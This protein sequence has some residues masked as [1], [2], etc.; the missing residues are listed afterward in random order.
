MKAVYLLPFMPAAALVAA[1]MSVVPAGESRWK[2]VPSI[3]S[4]LSA[5]TLL[6]LAYRGWERHVGPGPFRW[7]W[8]TLTAVNL[9]FLVLLAVAGP[10]SLLLLAGREGA[11]GRK[12]RVL[13]ALGH[14][15]LAGAMTAALSGHLILLSA[16]CALATWCAAAT[17]LLVERAGRERSRSWAALFPFLAS[18]LC[19]A[20]SVLLMALKGL[21]R[22]LLLSS[23]PAAEVDCLPAFV[24]MLAAAL[25]R[26][27]VFPLNA[28]AAF[29][30]G[31]GRA[32]RL[33]Y[34]QVVNPVLGGYL[35]FLAVRVVFSP[36]R[37]WQW[38]MLGVGS[39]VLA[40]SALS[41]LRSANRGGVRGWVAACLGG[42]FAL[43]L[44]GGGQGGAA[45]A[46][47][48]LLSGIPA[49]L[50]LE[51]SEGGGWRRWAGVAGG[52]ALLGIPPLAGFGSLW[53]AGSSL[54]EGHAGGSGAVF[55][56]GWPVVVLAF[57][58]GG[59]VTLLAPGGEADGAPAWVAAAVSLPLLAVLVL[60]GVYPGRVVDLFMREYGL[61]ME[62]PFS[63]WGSLAWASILVLAGLGLLWGTRV[64]GTTG[65]PDG[66]RG[67]K[68][69]TATPV[70]FM[71]YPYPFR[72]R[73]RVWVLAAVTAEVAMF[74]GWWGAMTLV[75]LR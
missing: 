55:F 66:E 24:L 2:Y 59:T 15:S 71:P 56:L 46:R 54:V 19:L 12:R 44:S 8:W 30:S 13:S 69:L 70:G 17:A 50:L 1:L 31:R 47:L 27:G 20:L 62:V 3:W 21:S 64:R 5:S 6:V 48:V 73:G 72:C 11:E 36:G 61:P 26:L 32:Y 67:S 28:C 35:L 45:A 33:P 37:E 38:V 75:L 9:V 63:S 52:A 23:F 7:G 51:A 14:L 57:L 42:A 10:L 22:G 65:M 25:L 49:L 60:V 74:L 68:A 53:M 58:V 39:A 29:L 40:S 4:F 18:D 34:L 16:G 41:L 43:S